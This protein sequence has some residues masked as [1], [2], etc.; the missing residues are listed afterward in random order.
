MC[1]SK[2]RGEQEQSRLEP[3]DFAR[4]NGAVHKHFAGGLGLVTEQIPDDGLIEKPSG[5]RDKED[6]LGQC[7]HRANRLQYSLPNCKN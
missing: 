5:G 4:G 1:F 2:L 3:D 6:L 7:L